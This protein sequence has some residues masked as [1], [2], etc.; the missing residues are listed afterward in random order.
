MADFISQLSG[1]EMDNALQEVNAHN[2]EAWSSGTRGGVQVASGDPTYDN[3]AKYW[4]QVAK[5]A[6]PPGS[7]GAVLFS[8]AQQ[9]PDSAKAQARANISAGG[10]NPNLLDNPWF[11]VNQR[12][13]T[14]VT[15][16]YFVDRWKATSNSSVTVNQD[17][18]ITLN[19]GGIQQ[20]STELLKK[21]LG[22]TVTLTVLLS[23]GTLYSATAT[24]P[25]SVS[26]TWFDLISI[27][28]SVIR[29]GLGV[30]GTISTSNVFVTYKT[31]ITIKAVKLELGNVST[32]ANDVAPNYEVELLKGMAST[33]DSSD[34]FASKPTH[35]YAISTHKNLQRAWPGNTF[36]FND[37][38]PDNAAIYEFIARVST[39]NGV[40]LHMYLTIRSSEANVVHFDNVGILQGSV[41]YDTA[42]KTLTITTTQSSHWIYSLHRIATF[43]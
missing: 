22:K 6:V 5:S 24:L 29:A 23:N 10:S 27:N 19:G 17:K 39:V 20:L 33:A 40:M 21:I 11:T 3:N 30:G 18:T 31:P 4:A 32:L 34:D 28:N 1:P 9:L 16:G 8:Q 37:V 13:A 15:S 36:I 35:P 2:A 38:E 41:T 26:I 14:S 42:T 25:N 43:V 12:G 7:A